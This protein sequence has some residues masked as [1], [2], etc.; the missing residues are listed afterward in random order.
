MNLPITVTQS[1]LLEILLNIAPSRP[2]FIWGAEATDAGYMTPEDIAG[3]VEIT[4][5]GGTILQPGVNA[6]EKSKDFPVTG[7][8]LIITDGYIESNLKIKREPD[9]VRRARCSSKIQERQ[10]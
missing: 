1:D 2:V 5:R 4:G 9:A 7:P 6:L 10:R 8:I 3:R